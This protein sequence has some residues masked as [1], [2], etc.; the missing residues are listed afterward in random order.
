MENPDDFQ[1]YTD[2]EE[3]KDNVVDEQREQWEEAAGMDY[4][5]AKKPESLFSLFSN[6]WRTKDSSKVANLNTEEIGDLGI[7]VRDCQRIALIAKLLHHQKFAKYFSDQGEITLS[8]SMSKKGWFVE[9]FVTSK[10]FA[11]KGNIENLAGGQP[12][13]QKW[14]IFSQKEE[15]A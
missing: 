5:A 8:T 12:K 1:E 13:K 4:P 9:M 14:R 10:K 2:E 3:F 11:Q 6:V 7:S 15:T